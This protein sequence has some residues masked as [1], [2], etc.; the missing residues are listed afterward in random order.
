MTHDLALLNGTVVSARGRAQTNVYVSEGR[1]AALTPE[2][3]Q[4][5]RVIDADGLFILPGM[6]DGHCHFQDPGDSSREI[7]R[8]H[9]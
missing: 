1:I 6:I 9:V 7:G 3:L 8:A 4:A 5:D 2:R